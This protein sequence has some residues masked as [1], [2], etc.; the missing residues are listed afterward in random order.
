MT[1]T[2]GVFIWQLTTLLQ[3]RSRPSEYAKPSDDQHIQYLLTIGG[4]RFEF[5]IIRDTL[6]RLA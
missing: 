1:Y 6:G 3:A 2:S 4:R 5:S